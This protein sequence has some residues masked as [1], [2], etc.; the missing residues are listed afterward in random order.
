VELQLQ[1]CVEIDPQVA[2]IGLTRRSSHPP[3]RQP[4]QPIESA[5][6]LANSR[7]KITE[8]SGECGLNQ[9]KAVSLK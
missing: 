3:P 5:C 1:S 6:I 8:S 4:P 9:T 2:Q 7:A